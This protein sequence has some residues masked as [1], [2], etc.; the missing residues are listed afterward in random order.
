MIEG[1]LAND[2]D[3]SVYEWWIKG[4]RGGGWCQG[5]IIGLLGQ[6]WLLQDI[7]GHQANNYTPRHRHNIH[8]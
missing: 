6:L 8:T 5:T 4:L 3:A 2:Y 1:Y 7:A